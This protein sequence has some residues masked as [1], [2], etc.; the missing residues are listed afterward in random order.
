MR[1][2][3]PALLQQPGQISCMRHS[4]VMGPSM[5][6]HYNS[7]L[8]LLGAHRRYQIPDS[9]HMRAFALNESVSVS[10]VTSCS[11]DSTLPCLHLHHPAN[12]SCLDSALH[13]CC[14]RFSPFAHHGRSST[15]MPCLLTTQ[16]V[17]LTSCLSVIL[18]CPLSTGYFDVRDEE[19]R[20]IRIC[21][22]KGDMIVLPEGIYHR[23]C[24]TACGIT[25]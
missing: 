17:W 21:T 15:G 25:L 12:H 5:C 7:L 22:R 1:W 24:H 9:K 8:I 19:D 6:A 18:C 20:W 3:C 2:R 10:D 11:R 14:C 23:E 4:L 16:G 13:P